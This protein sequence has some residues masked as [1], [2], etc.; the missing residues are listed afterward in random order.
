MCKHCCKLE[1]SQV[2]G[3]KVN[4]VL[5]YEATR[6]EAT[7]FA[8]TVVQCVR[9]VLQVPR[10]H[11]LMHRSAELQLHVMNV[12]SILDRLDLRYTFTRI[13]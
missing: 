10:A 7:H 1:S 4:R 5:S 8:Y 13:H 6:S 9:F 11:P 2:N 12:Y 3:L